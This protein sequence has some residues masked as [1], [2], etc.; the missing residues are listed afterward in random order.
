MDGGLIPWK[1][2][3]SFTKWHGRMGMFDPLSFDLTLTD[4]IRSWPHR[5]DT[6]K[7]PL[8]Y[9]STVEGMPLD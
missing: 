2:K 4:R 6:L 1:P 5:N 7:P 3:G 8:D 9:Q